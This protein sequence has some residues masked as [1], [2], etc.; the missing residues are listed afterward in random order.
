MRRRVAVALGLFILAV[1]GGCVAESAGGMEIAFV[2]LA[3]GDAVAGALDSSGQP[4]PILIRIRVTGPVCL[5][6]GLSAEQGSVAS[7]DNPAGESPFE[8]VVPWAPAWGAG[9]YVLEVG[10]TTAEKSGYAT[11]RIAVTVYGIPAL[12]RPAAP[13][14][15]G[16]AEAHIIALYQQR[17]GITLSAP[18]LARKERHGVFS[19]PWVSTAWIGSRFYQIDLFPDGH[20]ESWSAPV[21]SAAPDGKTQALPICRPGGVL[22]LLAVFLDYGNLGVTAADVLT[23]FDAATRRLNEIYA[24]YSRGLPQRSQSLSLRRAAW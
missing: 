13:L 1:A 18:A 8:V 11:A 14:P 17:F 23:A 4:V 16:E 21:G 2:G 3:D 22:T 19:D 12:P 6:V 7:I 5:G 15:R 24:S 20:D 10:A 9:V